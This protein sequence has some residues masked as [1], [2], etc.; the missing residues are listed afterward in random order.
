MLYLAPLELKSVL[1]TDLCF[2]LHARTAS[3]SFVH[4]WKFSS[5]YLARA[6]GF[7]ADIL[8]WCFYTKLP[9]TRAKVLIDIRKMLDE[10][11]ILTSDFSTV[12]KVR[13][14]SWRSMSLMFI[15]ACTLAWFC[16][17]L[18]TQ[19]I[20][21]AMAYCWLR[22]WDKKRYNQTAIPFIHVPNKVGACILLTL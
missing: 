1:A 18:K 20:E 10:L 9:C 7:T 3:P 17:E 21:R 16:T 4:C 13:G 8:I 15:V 19:P 5:A 12:R 2:T 11:G 22:Y 14:S 6:H